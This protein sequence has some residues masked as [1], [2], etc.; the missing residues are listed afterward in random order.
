MLIY[1]LRCCAALLAFANFAKSSPVYGSTD[2]SAA[3]VL[4]NLGVNTARPIVTGNVGFTCQV[5]Q[6]LFPRNDTFSV[7]SSYYT[8]LYE[9]PWSQTCWLEPACIVIPDTA[10]DLSK[11]IRVVAALKTKFAIRSGGHTDI[12]GFNSVGSDG[13]LIAL[14]NLNKLAISADKK[15]VTL[16]TGN[17]WSAVYKYVAEQGVAVVGGREPPVGVG[18]FL[19]GG[20][21]SLFYNAYGLG[22]DQI[23]RYQVVLTD[24]SIV[25]ATPKQNA[26]LYKALKGGLT[27]LGIV[28]EFEVLTNTNTDIY[29]EIYL[30]TP[31]HTPTL[32]Q[33]YANYLLRNGSDTSSDVQIQVRANYSLAF[34]GYN[35]HTER[36]A[37]F[38]TFYRIPTKSTFFPPTNGTFN[39]IIF[40]V[41]SATALGATYGSTFS[42]RILNADFL[43]ASYQTFL[44]LGARVP[45]GA[46][47][48]YVPQGVTP[49][50][51]EQGRSRN[52]GNLF[53]L[54][55]TP[56]V[57]IDIF[58]DYPDLSTTPLI[59]RIVDDFVTQ[60]SSKAVTQ[61]VDLPFLYVPDRKSVV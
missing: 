43:L 19:L 50:L 17:R 32:L 48:T 23:I 18:G 36:P 40:G 10:R 35:T 58:I 1:P 60:Q 59:Q 39:D 45:P 24:G 53:N 54:D 41:G 61:G 25:D 51:V 57:W 12:P 11:V 30:Y 34:Y 14:Q 5:L 22:I 6:E 44:D 28:T 13:V 49:N 8:P 26:D 38:D 3:T 42:H 46:V 37:V 56:Q 7:Q 4:A 27:N 52:G 31:E 20:G 9:I 29:Y 55:A 33:A 16:G 2:G 15:S 21:L 47:F